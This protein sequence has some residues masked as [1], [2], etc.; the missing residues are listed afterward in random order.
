MKGD[1][2]INPDAPRHLRLRRW[3]AASPERVFDAWV[4][5]NIAATWLFTGPTSE[6]HTT[7]IDARVGGAWQITDRREGVADTALG[8]YLEVDRPRRLVFTFAMPQ[9]TP[10]R[11]TITVELEPDGNGCVMTFTQEGIDIAAELRDLPTGERGDSESGWGPMF[12]RLAA[13][14]IQTEAG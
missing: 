3:F 12:D 6:S 1:R 9:F 4:N 5:A 13:V 2:L 7:E 10:N 11:D 8:E 14:L